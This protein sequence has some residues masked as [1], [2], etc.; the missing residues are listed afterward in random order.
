MRINAARSLDARLPRLTY[1]RLPRKSANA[2]V[3]V[4]HAQESGWPS[5]MLH[6][7]PAALGNGRDVEAVTGLNES[8][9]GRAE[10]VGRAIAAK[11]RPV[12]RAAVRILGGFHARRRRDLEESVGHEQTSWN[13]LAPLR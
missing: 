11:T 5:A 13:W 8:D 4:Q 10:A 1:W 12:V 9:L 3:F 2:K 6:I 7:R